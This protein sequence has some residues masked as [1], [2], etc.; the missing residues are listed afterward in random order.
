M[1]KPSSEKSLASMQQTNK[2]RNVYVVT[3]GAGA[4]MQ[5][6]NK[7]RNVYVMTPGVGVSTY[8]QCVYH[9]VMRQ[10]TVNHLSV[11]TRYNHSLPGNLTSHLEVF[12]KEYYLVRRH[13]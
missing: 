8:M 3:Q 5:Q 11:F 12:M 4:S 10:L 9:A 6:T 2:K 1:V 7:K 13:A